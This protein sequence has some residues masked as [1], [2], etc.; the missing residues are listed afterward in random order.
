MGAELELSGPAVRL[1]DWTSLRD[2]SP[3]ESQD[4]SNPTG[5]VSVPPRGVRVIGLNLDDAEILQRVRTERGRIGNPTGAS[6]P[7]GR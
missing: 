7:S 1:S 5:D 3:M 4:L 2:V 6:P